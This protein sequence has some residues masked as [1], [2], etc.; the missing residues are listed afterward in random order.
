MLAGVLPGKPSLLLMAHT[1]CLTAGYAAVFLTGGFGVYYVCCRWFRALSPARQRALN[2]G[3]FLISQISGG[4]VVAALLLGMFWSGRTGGGYFAGGPR[5]VGTLCTT[6]WLIA[7]CLIQRFGQVSNRVTMLLC[8]V[9]NMIVCL[10]WF[11]TGIVAQGNG[12]ASYWTL[13]ALLGVHL[14]FLL[15]GVVPRFETAE[16]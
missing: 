3:A 10:D 13:D 4:L 8:I 16:A 2:R 9:G 1:F 14:F 15:T 11:G 5:E 7:F 12:I 6:V